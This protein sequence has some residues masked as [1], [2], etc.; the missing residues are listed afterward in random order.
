MPVYN[1]LDSSTQYILICCCV[2]KKTAFT[3]KCLVLVED[4]VISCELV[5]ERGS[6]TFH[7]RM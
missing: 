5:I 7:L 3:S 4:E 1:P 6:K 2:S